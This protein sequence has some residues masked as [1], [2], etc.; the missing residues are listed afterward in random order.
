MGHSISYDILERIDTAMANDVMN[1]H[2]IGAIIPPNITFGPIVQAA[3]D[4][5]NISEETVDGKRR[6]DST[7]E[8]LYQIDGRNFIS[9][10][11]HNEMY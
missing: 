11:L 8:V 7:T 9:A 1:H 2:D 4:N 10:P 3:I 6:T 5:L